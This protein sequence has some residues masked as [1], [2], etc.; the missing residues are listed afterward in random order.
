MTVSTAE[1]YDAISKD[2]TESVERCVPKYKE[3]LSTL[4]TYLPTNYSPKSILELG[5]GTGNL[6]HLIS[7]HFPKSRIHAVDI[8]KEC[9]NECKQRLQSA[10]IDYI[11][12]DFRD[13]DF[14]EKSFDLII[15]SI[16]IHHL[17]DNEKSRLFKLLFLWQTDNG[18]LT[19][20]DQFKGESESIY[21]KHIKLWRGFTH[22]QGIQDSEWNQWMGHQAQHDY[23]KT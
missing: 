5:C 4:F 20:C 1:F 14:Q 16:S 9:I 19:F 21:K 12:S 6:T 13:L 2:Y 22:G 10:D 17:N 11:K 8:S 7:D 18:I 23:Q 3:M 15:S